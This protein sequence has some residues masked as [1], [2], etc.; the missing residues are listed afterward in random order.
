MKL[1]SEQS[2][3][4]TTSERSLPG[5]PCPASPALFGDSKLFKDDKVA[6]EKIQ[7]C[8]KSSLSGKGPT[9]KS[10]NLNSKCNFED[11]SLRI[12]LSMTNVFSTQQNTFYC[13]DHSTLLMAKGLQFINILEFLCS[14]C[15]LKS[16]QNKCH[17]PCLCTAMI[18]ADVSNY[19]NF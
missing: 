10:D 11:S 6:S 13:S 12:K 16:V 14:S 2:R 5:P 15:I 18:S 17:F 1:V 3:I 9:N 19:S 8:C 4:R 7:P